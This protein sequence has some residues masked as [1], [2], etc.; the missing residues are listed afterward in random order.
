MEDRKT[1]GI[2]GNNI[3]SEEIKQKVKEW[4]TRLWKQIYYIYPV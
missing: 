1:V 2:R 4:D 3:I